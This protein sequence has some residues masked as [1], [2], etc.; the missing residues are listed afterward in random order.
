[1]KNKPR[2]IGNILGIAVCAVMLPVVVINLALFIQ[3]QRRPD[4]VPAFFGIT[5]LI[6]TSGSMEPKLRVND[7]IFTRAVSWNSL[8]Q[9][10]VIAFVD[11]DGTVVTHRI[12]GVLEDEA[13]QQRFITQGDANNTAD[14]NHVHETQFI[15]RYAARLRGVGRV[16]LFAREPLGV[17]TFIGLPLGLFV[18]YDAIRRAWMNK[19]LTEDDIQ[20]IEGDS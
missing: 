9:D 4:D 17:V 7:L 13:G 16:A 15:G 12:A 5:P 3:R 18:L 14:A 8:E 10:D 11:Q 2:L 20:Q 19:K 6:V 1:M